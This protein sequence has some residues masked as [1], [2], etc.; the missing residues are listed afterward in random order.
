[1]PLTSAPGELLAGGGVDGDG[2]G[3]DGDRGGVDGDGGLKEAPDEHRSIISTSPRL[4]QDR[5]VGSAKNDR[6]VQ[7]GRIYI[8]PPNKDVSICHVKK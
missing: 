5:G 3:V 6:C 4:G 7:Q 2:G 1:M 8:G